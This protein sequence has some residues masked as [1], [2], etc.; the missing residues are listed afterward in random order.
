MALSFVESACG[1]LFTL[2]TLYQSIHKSQHD[3]AWNI[4]CLGLRINPEVTQY[5]PA[6]LF[7]LTVRTHQT[8][9]QCWFYVKP[10]LSARDA[11]NPESL[12]G[13]HA[14]VHRGYMHSDGS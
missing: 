6:I 14:C 11:A 1:G 13:L 7:T 9:A 8:H 12:L 10:D 3:A 4:D 2:N 5:F